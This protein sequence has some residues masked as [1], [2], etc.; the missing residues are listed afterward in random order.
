MTKQVV[1]FKHDFFLPSNIRVHSF[2]HIAKQKSI[3][4]S[5]QIVTSTRVEKKPRDIRAEMVF[6]YQNCSDLL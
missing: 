6:C 3:A 4:D 2:L 5:K 1:S